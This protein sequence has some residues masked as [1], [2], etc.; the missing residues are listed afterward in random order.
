MWKMKTAMGMMTLFDK[1][2]KVPWLNEISSESLDLVYSTRSS[3][4]WTAP[5]INRF[6]NDSKQ[7]L[8]NQELEIIASSLESI[9]NINWTKMWNAIN[10]DYNPV[11]NYH[12]ENDVTTTT[13]KT[14]NNKT[15]NKVNSTTTYSDTETTIGTVDNTSS[16]TVNVDDNIYGFNSVSSVNSD[17]SDTTSSNTS[18]TSNDVATTDNSTNSIDGTTNI[19]EDNT[20]NNTEVMKSVKKGNIGVMIYPSMLKAELDVRK[21]N[22]FEKVFTD[23]D[24][25][26]TLQVY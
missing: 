5:L 10:A 3:E 18:H 17:D 25:L 22:F 8:T 14:E 9:F 11:E 24:S 23:I 4:K 19:T 16:G 13:D 21:W 20:S 15:N 12:I 26:L 6:L 7:E 2:T 1:F